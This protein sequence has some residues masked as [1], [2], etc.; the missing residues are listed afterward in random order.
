M[1]FLAVLTCEACRASFRTVVEGE[2]CIGHAHIVVEGHVELWSAAH[3]MPGM[4]VLGP[5]PKEGHHGD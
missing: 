4:I 3:H 2:P 5:A 1:R